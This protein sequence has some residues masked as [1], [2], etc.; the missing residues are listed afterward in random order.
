MSITPKAP[1][2]FLILTG[3]LGDGHKQAAYA[4]AESA[5]RMYPGAKVRV[6][7]I[8]EGSHPRM[9]R[10]S[11]FLY[12]LWITKFP[13]LYGYLFRRTKTDTWLAH[14]LKRLRLCNPDKLQGLLRD[15]KPTV[16]VSTFPAASAAL[17]RL[18]EK[19]ITTVPSV[20]VITD[21]TYHSY[22]IHHGTDRYIVGSEHVRQALKSWPVPD[23]KIAV[24]GIPIRQAFSPVQNKE[25][26]RRRLRLESDLP[27][28]M[29]M[30]GGC[31]LIGGDWA[32]LLRDPALL[33][34]PMQVVIICGR[35]DK[36]KERLIMAMHGYP[37][38]VTVTGYV[39]N[40]HEWM[41]AADLLVTKPGGLTSSEALASELPM[42]LY[43]PLPGQEYDNAAFLTGIGA[44]VQAKNPQ[45]FAGHLF[46]LLE[47]P[48]LLR[49]MG[50]C[51]RLY[52]RRGAAEAAVLQI[53]EAAHTLSPELAPARPK[54]YAKA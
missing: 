23:R 28:V 16:V 35:N 38:P 40:V 53:M 41:A 44:A 5:S 4:V 12:M 43:K 25:E 1:P 29:I 37:H 48:E 49:Q 26:L 18:K 2:S 14:L 3:N 11:Q 34:K 39:D 30:G 15:A 46:H 45:E 27:V 36:L 20:T 33:G 54:V 32:R 21:Q 19:G 24:T 7:D 9:E 6:V 13:W 51:A 10:L 50:A 52:A 8:M 22:W 17:S 42:L 31:G 47:Q